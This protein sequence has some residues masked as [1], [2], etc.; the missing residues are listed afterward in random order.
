MTL[1]LQPGHVDMQHQTM[2][3]KPSK[4]Q[5][6]KCVSGD[7]ETGGCLQSSGGAPEHAS[8]VQ[9]SRSSRS[10]TFVFTETCRWVDVPPRLQMAQVLSSTPHSIS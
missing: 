2:L 8:E 4:S 7:S 3:P 9:L 6:P 5:R 1:P 10:T